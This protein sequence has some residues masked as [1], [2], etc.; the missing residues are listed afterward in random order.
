MEYAS[1]HDKL[2][3]NV[4]SAVSRATGLD[5]SVR[6]G[7]LVGSTAGIFSY[8]APSVASVTPVGTQGGLVTV[9][10]RSLGVQ[11]M[12]LLVELDGRRC[13]NVT[14]IKEHEQVKC[15]AAEGIGGGLD[16]TARFG[17]ASTSTPDIFSYAAPVVTSVSEVSTAGGT[18]TIEGRSFGSSANHVE[19]RVGGRKCEGLVVQR[20]H[21]VLTC[22]VAARAFGGSNVAVEVNAHGMEGEGA[23]NFSAPNISSITLSLIHI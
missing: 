3:C 20:S 2:V 16:A 12:T 22:L 21:S 18:I 23:M 14:Y 11:G 1:P 7:R 6:V 8:T 4:S 17:D 5:I 13:T 15:V 19:V 9:T 10:G